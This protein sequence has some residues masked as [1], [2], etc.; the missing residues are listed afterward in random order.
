MPVL[1]TTKE[2]SEGDYYLCLI[3]ICHIFYLT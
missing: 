2:G 3:S 1:E